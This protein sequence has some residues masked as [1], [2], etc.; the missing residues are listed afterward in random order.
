M[1]EALALFALAC[2][3]FEAAAPAGGVGE[4]IEGG[5]GQGLGGGG[6]GSVSN[7]S[8]IVQ[9]AYFGRAAILFDLPPPYGVRRVCV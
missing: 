2:E 4:E 5:G 1:G 3:R 7:D 8:H 6:G 9:L